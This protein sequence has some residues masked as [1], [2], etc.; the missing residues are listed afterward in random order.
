[1]KQRLF[2]LLVIC[3][4]AALSISGLSGCASTIN[5]IDNAKMQTWV[6]MSDSI[7]LDPVGLAKNRNIYV[8]TTNTSDMQDLIFEQM[9]RDDLA[10]K[11]FTIVADPTQAGFVVQSNVLYMDYEKNTLTADGLLAGGFGGALAGAGAGRS[12]G[13]AAAGGIIGAI[14]GALV[15]SA[16]HV[17]TYLGAVDVQI[18]EKVAGGVTGVM[19]T[20]AGQGS[21][22]T[23]KT[24]QEVKSDFQ[25]YR[26]R[27]VARAKQ[28]NIDKKEAAQM[29]SDKLATQIAGRF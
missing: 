9:L 1:M 24:Q 21:A 15:G 10:K 29:L 22:T 3:I 11:G 26:T 27:I 6:K 25:T 4:L 20:N 28:T 8:R 5:A 23:L 13:A 18:Q 19:V 17:D 14:G 2:A 12:G 7:F 16:F